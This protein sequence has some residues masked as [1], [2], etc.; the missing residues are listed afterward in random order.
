MDRITHSLFAFILAGAVFTTTI[1]SLGAVH[2]TLAYLVLAVIAFNQYDYRVNEGISLLFSAQV[3][4]VFA[5]GVM[6][7][8]LVLGGLGVRTLELAVVFALTLAFVLL[9]DDIDTFVPGAY[10][11]LAAFALLFGIF[12]YHARGFAANTGLGLFPVLA[13]IVLA[14]NLFV[15]PRYVDSD[16]VYWSLAAVATLVVLIGLPAVFLGDYTLWAFDVRAWSGDMTIPL[17]DRQVPVMRSIFANPN[18]LGLLLFPG[19]VAAV[20][21]THRTAVHGNYPFLAILPA[22][23][24]PILVLGLALSNSRAS[25]L[26]AIV[27]IGVYTLATTDRDLLPIA[28]VGVAV[29]LVLFLGAI[30]VSVL[31]IDPANRFAL[32]RAGIQAIYNEGSLL[33]EGIVG[34]G[35]VIEPYLDNGGSAVHNSYLSVFIRAGLL[36]GLA[37]TALVVGPIVQG[38]LGADRVNVP[39]FALATGF[40]VHQLFESYTLYQFGPGS[41]IG[42]LAVGYVIASLASHENRPVPTESNASVGPFRSTSTSTPASPPNVVGR[43]STRKQPETDEDRTAE[44]ETGSTKRRNTDPSSSDRL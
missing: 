27:A 41:V 7:I 12:L 3:T 44:S 23:T 25:M 4:L 9:R 33:G 11:Y 18:T 35:Q 37:Y 14:L 5:L 28:T 42:A 22:G 38:A 13:G 26:A 1:D 6:I 29:G 39:M 16:A 32:W 34:T 30:Y 31:G 43:E 10:P 17:I 21:A 8:T 19:T 36:G 24:V 2:L 40:A 20:V 15:V